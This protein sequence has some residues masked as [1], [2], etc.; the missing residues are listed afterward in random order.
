MRAS[1]FRSGNKA[2]R[3]TFNNSALMLGCP[4]AKSQAFAAATVS[5][6]ETRSTFAK[7]V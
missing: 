6:T 2:Q 3:R 7:V 1:D 4:S 5:N